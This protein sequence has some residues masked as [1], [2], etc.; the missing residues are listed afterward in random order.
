MYL[1]EMEKNNSLSIDDLVRIMEDFLGAG[2]ETSATTLKWIL[3]YLTV[4]PSVQER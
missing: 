2:T 4:N 3:L 1:I